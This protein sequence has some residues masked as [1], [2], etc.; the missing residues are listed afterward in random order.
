MGDAWK[1]DQGQFLSEFS[2]LQHVDKMH[3][4]LFSN[5][6]MTG[7]NTK[8][9]LYEVKL[10]GITQTIFDFIFKQMKLAIVYMR[11][12]KKCSFSLLASD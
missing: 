2:V 6:W 7:C 1:F 8:P 3:H 4:R 9:C 10:T 11:D 12:R 5:P